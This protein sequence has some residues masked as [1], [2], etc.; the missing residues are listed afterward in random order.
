[1]FEKFANSITMNVVINFPFVDHHLSVSL[2]IPMMFEGLQE[3]SLNLN[4]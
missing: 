2:C 1:M 3:K 4:Q